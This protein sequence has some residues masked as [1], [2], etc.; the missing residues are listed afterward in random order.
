ML[1]VWLRP[2]WGGEWRLLL[3][4]VPAVALLKNK[5]TEVKPTQMS[6]AAR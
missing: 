2:E 4:V 5:E 1:S 3:I 6:R